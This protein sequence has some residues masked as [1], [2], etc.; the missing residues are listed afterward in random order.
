MDEMI[1]AKKSR[2]GIRQYLPNKPNKWELKFELAVEYL[3]FYMLSTSTLGK[4]MENKHQ[5]KNLCKELPEHKKIL[6]LYFDNLFSLFIF[7]SN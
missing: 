5:L 7:L 4:K 2:S 1:I 3:V 6:K